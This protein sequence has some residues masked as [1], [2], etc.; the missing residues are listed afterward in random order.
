MIRRKKPCP[1]EDA[2]AAPCSVSEK[3]KRRF[4]RANRRGDE[5]DETCAAGRSVEWRRRGG[6]RNRAR[7][8]R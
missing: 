7:W 5:G 6:P 8:V 3:W 4:L 2:K 1:E